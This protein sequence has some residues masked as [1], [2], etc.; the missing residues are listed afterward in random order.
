MKKFTVVFEKDED[1][2]WSVSV[3]EVKGCRTQ[4]KTIEQGLRRIREALS[5]F[6]PDA[7]VAK[8]ELVHVV[9]VPTQ[10]SKAVLAA[11]TNMSKARELAKNAQRSQ[12]AAAIALDAAGVSRRDAA[13]IL[14]IS[15]Q[16]VQQITK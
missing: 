3:R 9:R 13:K 4:A 5:L 11:L 15:H 1:E 16:R 8:A 7:I 10:T 6:V 12:V 14:G 2:W